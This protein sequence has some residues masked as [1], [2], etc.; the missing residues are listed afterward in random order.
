MSDAEIK[1]VVLMAFVAMVALGLRALWGKRSQRPSA[2]NNWRKID[3]SKP[4]RWFDD[5]GAGGDPMT[6]GA[7]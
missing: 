3:D 6:G 5:Q 1:S 2:K 4:G 7:E